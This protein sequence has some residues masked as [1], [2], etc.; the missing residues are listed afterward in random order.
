[1]FNTNKIKKNDK[2]IK[3]GMEI[4]KYEYDNKKL[5]IQ[6]N[7]LNIYKIIDDIIILNIDNETL[8]MFNSLDIYGNQRSNKDKYI[9]IINK[10]E[11]TNYLRIKINEKTLFYFKGDNKKCYYY[12]EIKD[13]IK[14][15]QD[16]KMIIEIMGLIKSENIVYT[17][18]IVR[19]ILLTQE[20][21]NINDRL[22][23]YAFIET[24]EDK[25]EKSDSILSDI[26]IKSDSIYNSEYF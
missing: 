8:N 15:K 11:N 5:Y 1:M 16:I 3:E 17:N 2:I 13:I 6:T 18:I 7:N 23:N 21:I 9:T 20:N 12:N 24:D 26:E 25:K 22:D 14:E 10:L 19:Q 4:Y